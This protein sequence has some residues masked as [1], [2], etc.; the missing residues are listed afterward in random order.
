MTTKADIELT[1]LHICN[2]M[3]LDAK[4]PSE[5][6]VKDAWRE[7]V[8]SKDGKESVASKVWKDKNERNKVVDK[9]REFYEERR[10][11]SCL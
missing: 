8:H 4:L 7:F 9:V 5:S 11:R 1:V 2:S 6:N 10:R 3:G